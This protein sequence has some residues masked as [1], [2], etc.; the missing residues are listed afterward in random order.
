MHIIVSHNQSKAKLDSS[1][2]LQ[3]FGDRG[4][5]IPGWVKLI[6]YLFIHIEHRV[7][8]STIIFLWIQHKI[9]PNFWEGRHGVATLFNFLSNICVFRLVLVFAQHHS[10]QTIRNN[11]TNRAVAKR[12]TALSK[13]E[14]IYETSEELSIMV[15]V[16]SL[17]LALFLFKCCSRVVLDLFWMLWCPFCVLIKHILLWAALMFL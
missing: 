6:N 13:K 12:A 9:N 4:F 16:L 1:C 7:S 8:T 11:R 17:T 3:L 2:V 10:L 14:N 15:T 5:S